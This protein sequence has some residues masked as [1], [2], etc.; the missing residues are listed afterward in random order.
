MIPNKKLIEQRFAKAASTYEEQA[1]IQHIVADELLGSLCP[2][3]TKPPSSILEVGCCTGL[4]TRRLIQKFPDV[5][6]FTAIDLVESFRPYV[7]QKISTINGR[8]TFISGD[9]ESIELTGTYDLIVSSSTFH[10]MHNLPALFAKLHQHLHPNGLLAIS[11][12]GTHN[13]QEIRDITQ[14]GLAYESLST[15]LGYA[16]QCFTVIKEF[17]SQDLLF[18]PS[19]MAVLQ[20]LRQTGVNAVGTKAWTPRQLKQFIRE[21][22]ERFAEEQGVRLTY[23]P[24]YFMARP[25]HTI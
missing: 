5:I 23:H 1:A 20:H 15:I 9:I 4:L 22:K 7:E 12:Y 11:L 25:K 2:L 13:L 17:E 14:I 18:F 16:S 3:L 8:G 24:M 19:P 21:Y 10:W 6:T